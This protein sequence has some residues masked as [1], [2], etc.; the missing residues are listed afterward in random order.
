MNNIYFFIDHE[1]A[2]FKEASIPNV[3]FEKGLCQKTEQS[4]VRFNVTGI[5]H[6]NQNFFVV[7]PKGYRIPDNINTKVTLAK[8]IYNVLFKYK[9]T[10]ILEKDESYWLGDTQTTTTFDVSKKLIDDFRQ[11]GLITLQKRTFENN[12]RGNINWPKTFKTKTPYIK[13]SE[14]V[15][16]DF[17]TTKNNIVSNETISLIHSFILWNIS[18]TYGWLFNFKYKDYSKTFTHS[19]MRYNLLRALN[20][21]YMDRDIRIIKFLLSY[22]DNRLNEENN[23]YNIFVT[24]YFDR[25]WETICAKVMGNMP[26]LQKMVPKPYWIYLEDK[27]ETSQIPDILVQMN[28]DELII[29]DAKYYTLNQNKHNLPGWGDIVKQLFYRLSLKHQ[30]KKIYNI[31]LFPG[32][33]KHAFNFSAYASVSDFEATFGNVL[34]YLLDI[35]YAIEIYLNNN[36]KQHQLNYKILKDAKEKYNKQDKL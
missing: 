10:K 11:N 17:V 8:K 15:Y 16:L 2:K 9:S 25:V 32:T 34:G 29:Y 21:T 4:Y 22:I 19:F 23:N 3:F 18:D 5:I 24:K 6:A 33:V 13:K 31:F 30:Y 28:K 7:L 12:G 27:K 35:D 20:E 1:P 26:M 36:E 14:L